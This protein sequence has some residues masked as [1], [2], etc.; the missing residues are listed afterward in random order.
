MRLIVNMIVLSLVSGGAMAAIPE[1]EGGMVDVRYRLYRNA[2]DDVFNQLE[3]LVDS[4][5]PDARL[6][7]ADLLAER[8][9][10]ASVQRAVQLYKQSFNEGYGVVRALSS[11]VQ[12]VGQYPGM[13]DEERAFFQAS[14]QGFAWARDPESVRTALEVFLVY[15]AL[16]ANHSMESLIALHERSCIENCN[17][18]LYLAAYRAESGD[19]EQAESLYFEA[20]KVS[21]RAVR[22]Y[23]NWIEKGDGKLERL[24]TFAER[25]K[26]FIEEMSPGAIQQIG[27]RM[28]AY[29][30]EY[31]R[32]VMFWFDQAAQKGI[33]GARINKVQYMLS[34]PDHYSYQEAEA[35]FVQILPVDP[36]QG[37]LLQ[38]SALTVRQWKHLNPPKA[39][40]ILTEL[41][42][43]GHTEA[44]LG[45]GDLYS[46]GG[47]DEVAQ[48]KAIDMYEQAAVAGAFVGYQ[49]IAV[50]YRSGRGICH[51][52]PYAL[53]YSRLAG[54]YDEA[55]SGDFIR[56][57]SEEMSPE[58]LQQAEV[59]HLDLRRQYHL[60]AR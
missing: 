43:A 42:N 4:G 2:Q 18:T 16:F 54:S 40:Q 29:S 36:V 5:Y 12:L 23:A 49:K 48:R 24:K 38:A 30:T 1:L 32:E 14:L 45:L 50:I 51:S 53:A 35:E 20:A 31:D 33:I 11:M 22:L 15:P 13:V 52:K 17:G 3:R 21:P 59:L 46:M 25:L 9:D 39:H 28:R 55:L 56:S 60:E 19:M 37:Q 26:P 7:L 6:T 58:E 44:T 47:L 34:Y 8:D 57:L 10:M 41:Y 27:S